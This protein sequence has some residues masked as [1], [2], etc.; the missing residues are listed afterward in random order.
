MEIGWARR[1]IPEPEARTGVAGACTQGR[2]WQ[3]PA[4]PTS[5]SIPFPGD[6]RAPKKPQMPVKESATC[7]EILVEGTF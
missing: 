2:R 7:L 5:A 4:C 6:R 1:H 3:S